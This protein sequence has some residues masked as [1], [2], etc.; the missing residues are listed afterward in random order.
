M[1]DD[2]QQPDRLRG[3]VRFRATRRRAGSER[4]WFDVSV[5][6]LAI[7]RRA[8]KRAR[9]EFVLLLPLLAAVLTLY[10][11]RGRVFPRGWDTG[12][13]LATAI[14]LV[15]LGWKLARSAG[16]ALRPWLFGH[17]EPATAGT[18]GF[19]IRL[20]TMMA[21]VVVALRI[22]G[23]GPRELA[24]GGAV[25]VVVVGLAAQQTLG[26]VIAGSVLATAQPFHVGE[27]VRMQGG[28]L[29]GTIEG[30]VTSLG[31]LYTTMARG[32][33]EILI[34]NSVV[35]NVAVVPLREPPGIDLRARLRAGVTP[36]EVE[37]A[38]RDAIETP[39]RDG[40]RVYLEEM[41]AEKVVVRVTATSVRPSDGPRLASEVLEALVP[42][43]SRGEDPA[44]NGG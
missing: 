16:R 24:L 31:L 32:E 7:S 38:L 5:A 9:I 11:Y 39:L 17:L 6:A 27:R 34:P 25:S 44:G 21:V 33:D 18:A 22:A 10:G 26:H 19:L 8:V 14:A 13:R 20:T 41:D 36:A 42:Y 15:A 30:Q 35:L 12:V 23:L 1:D 40:P 4:P 37:R 2:R 43:A 28:P 29:A 3:P